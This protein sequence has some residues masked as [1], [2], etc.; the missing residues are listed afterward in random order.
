LSGDALNEFLFS[1]DNTLACS[2]GWLQIEFT[3]MCDD[4]ELSVDDP[5][6]I[7]PAIVL[8]EE[9][10]TKTGLRVNEKKRAKAGLQ[11]ADKDQVVHGL[12]VNSSRGTRVNGIYWLKAVAVA[13]SYRSAAKIATPALLEMLAARRQTVVGHMHNCRQSYRSP[14]KQ[15]RRSL[16]LGDR[17]IRQKLVQAGLGSFTGRWWTT[18]KW[19]TPTEVARHW[20]AKTGSSPTASPSLVEPTQ[21]GAMSL[22]TAYHVP[23]PLLE[24]AHDER[25]ERAP[26]YAASAS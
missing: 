17:F 7:Q 18:S 5:E 21:A 14:A 25:R 4:F 24:P 23:S 2:A 3:R 6:L 20:A 13:E 26:L 1:C 12:V 16:S 19:S 15:I 8:V 9:S 11:P 22:A 10:I